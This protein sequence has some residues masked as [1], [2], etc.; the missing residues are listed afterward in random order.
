MSDKFISWEE[1]VAWLVLQPDKQD[2]VRDCYFDSSP[3]V[4][5]KRY[6]QS[7]EWKS[8]RVF[9]PNVPAG[10]V[11]DLGAGRG[12]A[13]YA[14]AKEGWNVMAVE[15]DSSVLVGGGAIR[16]VAQS[17]GL[18]IKVTQ[19]FGERLPFEA[20]TFDLI[21]ARQVL[22]HARDLSMLCAEIFRVLKPGGKFIA[23]RDH[24]I[25][26]PGDLSAF[27]QT[28]PLHQLYGGENAFQ[29]RQY[30]TAVLSAGFNIEKTL[31]P[32]DSVINYA[33]YTRDSL[34]DELKR[35]LVH[36]P[37]GRIVGRLLNTGMIMDITLALLSRFDNRPGRLYSFI[38]N[39]PL[40]SNPRNH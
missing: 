38:C 32:F 31:R 34:R 29:I 18:P 28:H 8:I 3:E 15:P 2:L 1:A 6:W 22:H 39:K 27:L 23:V 26:S 7:E 40:D 36:L 17:E 33:P 30:R 12:I 9:L 25:S 37:M 20:A 19:E 13:S 35:R 21:F 16:K 10:H 5:A 4:A 14:L 24:V 11:L